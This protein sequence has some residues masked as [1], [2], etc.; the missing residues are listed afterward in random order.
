MNNVEC[1]ERER[2]DDVSLP[3]FMC[4]GKKMTNG[5]MGVNKTC[6]FDYCY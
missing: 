1:L 2:T 6:I 5:Q 4:I 3:S